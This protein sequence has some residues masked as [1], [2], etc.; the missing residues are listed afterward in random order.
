MDQALLKSMSC[1]QGLHTFKRNEQR[2][3]GKRPAQPQHLHAALSLFS[4]SAVPVFEW[5]WCSTTSTF[6]V[7]I[8]WKGKNT[9]LLFPS[10]FAAV[11]LLSVVS[12]PCLL[13]FFR[14]WLWNLVNEFKIYLLIYLLFWVLWKC[15][16]EKYLINEKKN[17][18]K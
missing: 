15:F 4:V 18:S 12:Y 10:A 5:S 13:T 1:T 14:L 9:P 16:C 11:E 8:L 7:I 3:V 17:I 2:D 6:R